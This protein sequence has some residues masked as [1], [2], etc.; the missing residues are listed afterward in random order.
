VIHRS[1]RACQLIA[2]DLV[3]QGDLL[4]EKLQ[5]PALAPG[6]Q[7]TYGFAAWQLSNLQ[8]ARKTKALLAEGCFEGPKC[9]SVR[10]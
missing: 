8:L 2:E 6:G 4:A 10:F 9:C 1:S 3:F 7:Q 5:L